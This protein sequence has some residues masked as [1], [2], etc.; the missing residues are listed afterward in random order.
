MLLKL[1]HKWSDYLA[2]DELQHNVPLAFMSQIISGMLMD[3]VIRRALDF[4][5]LRDLFDIHNPPIA[6]PS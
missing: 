5:A 6:L 4:V 3:E 1:R 2:L